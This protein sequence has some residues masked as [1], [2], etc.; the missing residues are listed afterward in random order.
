MFI[1]S[2]TETNAQSNFEYEEP[3]LAQSYE[4]M[5]AQEEYPE[6]DRDNGME[7]PVEENAEFEQSGAEPESFDE[8]QEFV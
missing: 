2:S 7:V 4:E 3:A 6:E 1:A 8:R 5:P